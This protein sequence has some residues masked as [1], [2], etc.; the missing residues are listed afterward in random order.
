[1]SQST[2]RSV[3]VAELLAGEDPTSSKYPDAKARIE[4][5]VDAHAAEVREQVATEID[6][7]VEQNL[8]EY[9]DEPAM[10]ARRL[11]LAAAARI[12]RDPA[13]GGAR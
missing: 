11:G 9:P 7:A 13:A 10:S 8:A 1:M 12:A 5:L 2:D 6:T 3:L 4:R